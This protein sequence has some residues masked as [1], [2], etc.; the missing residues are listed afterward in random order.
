[1][2]G[3]VLF[4]ILIV[5]PLRLTAFEIE[6][7]LVLGQENAPTSIRIISTT[8]VVLFKPILQEFLAAN[9]AKGLRLGAKL[10]PPLR[11]AGGRVGAAPK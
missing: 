7:S 8:D 10:H 5:F 2:R 11:N 6:D 1:M 3:F 9:P 4:F